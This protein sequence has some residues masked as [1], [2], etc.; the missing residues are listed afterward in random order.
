[1]ERKYIQVILNFPDCYHIFLK[2][3]ISPEPETKF[4]KLAESW[5]LKANDFEVIMR[6]LKTW[7]FFFRNNQKLEVTLFWLLFGFHFEEV[8]WN[9]SQ[10]QN[11]R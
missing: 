8:E 11:L 1:M 9:I 5:K 7:S 6:K 4:G 10:N 2:K 3:L